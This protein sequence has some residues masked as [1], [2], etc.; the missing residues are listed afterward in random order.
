LGNEV[1]A[2]WIQA[3]HDYIVTELKD[4]GF[5]D[6][7]IEVTRDREPS[8]NLKRLLGLDV[9]DACSFSPHVCFAYRSDDKGSWRRGVASIV[10]EELTIM[11]ISKCREP[12]EIIG[13]EVNLLITTVP[14]PI[15]IKRFFNHATT[16][17]ILRYSTDK[18][19]SIGFF[20]GSVIVDW[21]LR[22]PIF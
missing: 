8:E 7:I 19:T 22:A 15:I 9:Q 6:V 10:R 12:A 20:K 2:H 4:R 18:T 11:D 17:S 5:A 1:R 16:H 13:S 3:V 21:F 14:I